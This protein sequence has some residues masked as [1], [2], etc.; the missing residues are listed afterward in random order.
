MKNFR[1]KKRCDVFYAEERFLGIFWCSIYDDY[2]IFTDSRSPKRY[3]DKESAV[4]ALR[5]YIK[6]KKGEKPEFWYY[7]F[8]Y[9]E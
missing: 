1:I 7:S 9:F 3:Y 4:R 8:S 2:N 6:S 5:N